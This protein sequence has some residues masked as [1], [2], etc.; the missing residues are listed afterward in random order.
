MWLQLKAEQLKKERKVRVKSTTA[1]VVTATRPR[2][3]NQVFRYVKKPDGKI[4][5]GIMFLVHLAVSTLHKG[6][7]QEITAEALKTGLAN[8]TTQDPTM[9]TSIMLH[10]MIKSGVVEAL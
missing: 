6:T 10:R 7:V 3:K 4:P 1:R 9:Q 5:S 8:V 2:V